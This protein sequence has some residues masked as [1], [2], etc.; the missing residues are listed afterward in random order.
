MIIDADVLADKQIESCIDSQKNFIVI[1]GAGSGKTGSLIKALLHVRKQ[2]KKILSEKGQRVACI[3]YTNNAVEEIR[4]RTDLDELFVISTIHKFLWELI[5]NFQSDIRNSV[6]KYLIPKRIEKKQEDTK[7]NSKKAVAARKRIE[8][9]ENDLKNLP[10]VKRFSY[11]DLGS[12]NYSDG[13]LDHDD[14]IDLASAM[15]ENLPILRRIIGQKFPYIFIDEAQDTF[16]NVMNALNSVTKD[17]GLPIIGYFGDPMQQIFDDNRAGE[18][19]G[20]EGHSIIQKTK[21]YRCSTEVI[22]LLNTIRPALPQSPGDCNKNRKGSV[23]MRLVQ[24][25]DGEGDRKSY[26]ERQLT[27]SLK[28][29]DEALSYFGWLDNKEVKR[30]FL[31]RQMIAHR[32]GFSGLNRLFTGKYAS[33]H[34]E[35]AFKEGEHLVLKHFINTLLPLVEYREANNSIGI[36][37]IMREKSPL[38][39]PNGANKNIALKDVVSLAKE[40]IEELITIWP[41]AS[42]KTILLLAKKYNLIN[43]SERLSEHLERPRRVEEYEDDNEDHVK[44]KSDWLIDELFSMGT[45]ELPLYR[46]FILNLTPFDTQHGVKGNQFDKV[47]VVYDDTEARWNNFSFSGLLTPI[48]S[49]KELTDGQKQRSL[50]LAYVCFSRTKEDLKIIL[51]VK[52]PAQ[53]KTELIKNYLFREDQISLAQS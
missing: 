5:E 33:K 2:Q 44:E 10:N 36:T 22:N 40:A 49:G 46:D 28:K 19:K 29:F 15:I 23:E 25:E 48:S 17:E 14:V 47:L 43:F 52:N 50:N 51:F 42:I 24:A 8:Q 1:A 38:L 7:G 3:T 39:N 30:L 34:S 18:F 35:D 26:S 20:P 16:S 53:A 32:A 9:L 37:N 41:N 45:K 13:N 12:R 6:A 21:N 27:D 31:T 11:D 4:S